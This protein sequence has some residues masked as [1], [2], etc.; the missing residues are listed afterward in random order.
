MTTTDITPAII[1]FLQRPGAL[2]TWHYERRVQLAVEAL[3]LLAGI[4]AAPT[5]NAALLLAITAP[6]ALWAAELARADR[7]ASARKTEQAAAIGLPAVELSCSKDIER[8]AKNRQLV[9]AAAPIVALATSVAG[10]GIGLTK[11]AVVGFGT[12]LVRWSAI[13]V[14][15]AWRRW[16]RKRAPAIGEMRADSSTAMDGLAQ[17]AMNFVQYDGASLLAVQQGDKVT[18][19]VRLKPEMREIFER[20]SR[21]LDAAREPLPAA[22]SEIG[23]A[24]DASLPLLEII[25]RNR[26]AVLAA[27]KRK[28]PAEEFEAWR[29]TEGRLQE[30]LDEALEQHEHT[31]VVARAILDDLRDRVDTYTVAPPM[32]QHVDAAAD[33]MVAATLA[34]KASEGA[35]GGGT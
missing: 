32:D 27:V 16:Y 5:R 18:I 10:S 25:K 4:W 34:R 8:A 2:R 31:R 9:T 28:S 21:S 26:A 20:T 7:S 24:G 19:T 13:E 6:L 29:P 11:A 17:R 15:G 35:R 33:R 12:S 23:C 14:Y 30:V 22:S 1:R 3:C